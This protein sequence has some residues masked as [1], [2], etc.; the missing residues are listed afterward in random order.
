VTT[1]A[2]IGTPA[3]VACGLALAR[4][5]AAWVVSATGLVLLACAWAYVAF[6]AA[7]RAQWISDLEDVAGALWQAAGSPRAAIEDDLSRPAQV[8]QSLREVRGPV[9]LRLAS[10][11]QELSNLRAVYDA[12][13]SPV[14]ATDAAGVVLAA[15][16][17]A[18]E[19][20][21]S[22]AR[23]IGANID[24]LFTQA[25]VL[26]QHAAAL[27]GSSRSSQV[28]LSQPD[29]LRVYQVLTSPI[30]LHEG[31]RGVVLTMR[32]V[33]ELAQAVQLKTDFVANASHELRTP[34][35]SIRAATETLADGAWDD[36]S[37]R[38]RLTSVITSNAGRLEEMVRDLL[39]LSRLETPDAP[40]T[41]EAV[42]LREFA[43][44]LQETFARVCDER[45]L[46]LDIDLREAPEQI[47]TDRKLLTVIVR[48][49]I[50]NATKFAYEGTS[51]AV[52]LDR[53]GD[54]GVRVR[55]VDNGV[56]IPLGHQQRIFER[57]YQVDPSRAG[58][59]A[60]RGTGLGLAIVKH[61]V[62]A[63]GGTIV[64]DSVWKQG[65]TMTVELPELPGSA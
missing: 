23:L 63:L 52:R 29:G 11:A 46:T 10:T 12:L 8:T 59:A 19:F 24:E 65:T 28:R 42:A 53:L 27:A 33:T 51:V 20:F 54:A 40:V 17:A 22:R 25:Q 56:G 35:S 48:N 5:D 47:E 9:V 64:V 21:S 18:R 60:R 43:Q 38:E 58:F 3:M 6:V 4:V 14:L 2:L 32:D 1:L 45:S 31:V 36:A 7:K 44:Q 55:V 41:R 49:L 37:M 62:K 34:L 50:D 13:Q 15:N 30:V 26:G 57:F 61:A 16:A 39:D